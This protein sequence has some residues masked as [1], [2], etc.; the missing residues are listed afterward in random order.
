MNEASKILFFH[1]VNIDRYSNHL[2]LGHTNHRDHCEEENT[3]RLMKLWRT[4]YDYSEIGHGLYH[5][6]IARQRCYRRRHWAFF[7]VQR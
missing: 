2:G 3:N 5:E 6:A 1:F 7:I 4:W